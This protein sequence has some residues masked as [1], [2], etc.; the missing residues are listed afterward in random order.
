MNDRRP[1]DS[2]S[3]RAA[4]P[5][6]DAAPAF[7]ASERPNADPA[8]AFFHVV[9]APLEASVSYGGGAA[10]GPA[11]IIEASNYLELWDGAS[12]PADAGIHTAAAVDCSRGTEE[13]LEGIRAAVARAYAAGAVPV[14]LGGEHTVTC[15]AL[16][17]TAEAFGAAEVGIVQFDAHGDLRDS[18]HG[19]SLSHACVMRRGLDLGFR[20]FQVGQRSLSAEDIECRRRF[21]IPHLDAR[22]AA[23]LGPGGN[24]VTVLSLPADFPRLVYLSFD[25]D[26]LDPSVIPATGTP[27][28]GGLGWYQSLAMIESVAASGRRIVGFDVVELAPDGTSRPSEFAAARLVYDIMG[29]AERAVTGKRIRNGLN[30]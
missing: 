11:A 16:R 12:V 22:E 3:R 21:G 1:D 2:G 19:D 15:G 9:P 25:V 6:P 10:K 5:N 4:G 23:G 20:L 18:Y 27:E 26:G 30:S 14:L 24:P 8:K 17:A 28:P 7:L 13:A 29:I